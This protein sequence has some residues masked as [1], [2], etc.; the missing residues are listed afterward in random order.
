FNLT[1]GI[2]QPWQ[3]CFGYIEVVQ[4]PVAVTQESACSVVTVNQCPQHSLFRFVLEPPID[5]FR[6]QFEVISLHLVCIDFR[7]S[8]STAYLLQ[9]MIGRRGDKVTS[10]GH[11]SVTESNPPVPTNR[12]VIEH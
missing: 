1:S 6:H 11:F 3:D 4:W 8:D 10:K 12:S 9:A 5:V 7:D 2:C